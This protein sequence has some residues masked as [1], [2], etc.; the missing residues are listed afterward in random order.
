MTGV[1]TCALPIYVEV[2]CAVR[3]DGLVYETLACYSLGSLLTDAR[4]EEN[5]AG[6]AV[7]I[8][9]TYDPATRRVQLGEAEVTPLYIARTRVND[10]PVYRVVNCEDEAAASML[11]AAELE[12]GQH[13]AQLIRDVTMQGEEQ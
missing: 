10:A 2:I 3:P 4:S 11:D 13:A 1:Q 8:R 9:V 7:E 12:A 5:T 6:M